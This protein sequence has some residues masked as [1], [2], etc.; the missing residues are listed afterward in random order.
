M[1][2]LVD[3]DACPGRDI[4]EQ[5]AKKY[6]LDVIMFCDINHVLNSSYSIIR[7]VDHGFQSVDMVLIN[8]VKE[9]D[10]I[11]TQDF[12]VAAMALGKKAKA[13]NPKGYIF[14]NN[15]IDR[16]LF[17]RHISS[18]MRRA[19]IKNTSNHKKRNSEDNARL[20][21]NLTKLIIE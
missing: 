7:Y 6:N 19:G 14:S 18:K 15:N 21:K 12:G 5:V 8:E 13:I 17:E 4:I 16:M 2:I 20:E 3:A 9:N 11:I 1:R 10:I